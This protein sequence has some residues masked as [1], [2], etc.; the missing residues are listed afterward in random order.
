VACG[1]RNDAYDSYCTAIAGAGQNDFPVLLV[2]SE[3]AVAQEPW[4][5]LKTRDDWDRPADADDEHAQLMVQCMEAW[6][7][8]DR[9]LLARFYGHGFTENAL[10]GNRDIEQVPKQDVFRALKMATRQSKTKGE[11]GKGDHSFEIL[12]QLDPNKVRT[13]SGHAGKLLDTLMERCGP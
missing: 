8:A 9:E 13:A 1:S 4:N 2:D 3:A 10:P 11:Y 12:G 5:H 7:L 6:F